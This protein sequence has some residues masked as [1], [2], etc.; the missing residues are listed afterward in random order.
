MTVENIRMSGER[1]DGQCAKKRAAKRAAKRAE[2][3]AKEG[4]GK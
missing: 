2:E 1:G 3:R 4:S